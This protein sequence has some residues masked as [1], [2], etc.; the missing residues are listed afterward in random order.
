MIPIAVTLALIFLILGGL[1]F[2][3][4]VFGIQ[5]P[6]K[7]YPSQKDGNPLGYTPGKFASSLV[8]VVLLLFGLLFL[9]P[10]L[11][12]FVFPL[13]FYVLM[14]IGILFLLRGIGD[15]KYLGLFKTVSETPFAKMDTRFYTP[16]CFCIAGMV[17][18]LLVLY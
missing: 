11:S 16:L 13:E 10:V 15:F 12:L 9:N 14:G 8:G 4:A 2:Y 7:V 5:N 1:H 6:E 18:A 3:W 17:F